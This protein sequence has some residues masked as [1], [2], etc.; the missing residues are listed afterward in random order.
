VISTVPSTLS[1]FTL[2]KSLRQPPLTAIVQDLRNHGESPH[3]PRH[4]YTALAED[5]EAF[6]QEHKIERP[7][8]IGHSMY[9]PHDY[10]IS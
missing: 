8:L 9:A 10:T 4:D 5:V 1:Y 6:L 3:D 7:A 2:P